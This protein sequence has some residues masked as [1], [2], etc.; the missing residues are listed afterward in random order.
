MKK[1]LFSLAM[2]TLTAV[3]ALTQAG[4]A[5]GY[6]VSTG[7][8]GP[9][10]PF[11][12][13]IGWGSAGFYGGSYYRG[14]VTGYANNNSGNIHSARGGSA[15]W[16]DGSGS[17]SG[18][19]GGSASWDDGSGSAHGWRGGSASWGGGSGSWSGPRGG[20]GSWHR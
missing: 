9:V 16:N 17:A 19:R 18:W 13:G 2:V 14:G 5:G 15:S 7:G 10:G 4:C 6:V 3:L 8:P 1:I 20:G 11:Y 12:P